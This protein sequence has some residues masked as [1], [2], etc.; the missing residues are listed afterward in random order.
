MSI[1]FWLK[2]G[3]DSNKVI[4][5]LDGNAVYNQIFMP[6]EDIHKTVFLCHSG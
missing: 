4:S 3:C 5:F 6:K 2:I 1:R